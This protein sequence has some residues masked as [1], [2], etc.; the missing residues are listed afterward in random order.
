MALWRLYYHLVWATKERQPFITPKVEPELY[1]YILGKAKMLDY[2]VHALGG[3][4]D[5]IHIVASIS[6]KVSISKFVKDIKG[7]SAYHISH[8]MNQ[9]ENNFNWQ[10]GYGVFSLGSK[11]LDEAIAYVLNQKA[12]HQQNKVIPLLEQVEEMDNAPNLW[13]Q[14]KVLTG[15]KPFKANNF[16]KEQ[17]FD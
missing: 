12:H 1:G 10:K 7:S 16:I 15:I 3:V 4:E 6:P 2:I 5:H 14:G 13:N 8:S 9:P 17:K 11:Q